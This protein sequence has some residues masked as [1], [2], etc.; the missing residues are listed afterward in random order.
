M[1]GRHALIVSCSTIATLEFVIR[2][3][4][5][6]F[7]VVSAPGPNR[8]LIPEPVADVKVTAVGPVFAWLEPMDTYARPCF[9]D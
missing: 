1:G 7:V 5:S 4:R 2:G 8:V 9:D 3:K 6:L